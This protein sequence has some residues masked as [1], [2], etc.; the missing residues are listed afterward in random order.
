MERAEFDF[1]YNSD[2]SGLIHGE[3]AL[4]A[5]A[6]RVGMKL[7]A[8]MENTAGVAAFATNADESIALSVIGPSVDDIINALRSKFGA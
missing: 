1:Q 8:Y 5:A 2:G 3:R 6:A 7:T 4:R